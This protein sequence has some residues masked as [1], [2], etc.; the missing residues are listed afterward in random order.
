MRTQLQLADGNAHR[1]ILLAAQRDLER[2]VHLDDFTCRDNAAA[3]PACR[4]GKRIRPP[5]QQ[6]LGPWMRIEE[7]P[8]SRQRHRRAVIAA[9]AVD[10]QADEIERRELSHA[11]HPYR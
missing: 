11:A 2:I 4:S 1:R 7:C 8:A 3:A 6:Q 10:R 9:H 5:H